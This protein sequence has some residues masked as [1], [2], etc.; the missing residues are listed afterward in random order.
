MV[1]VRSLST[2][3]SSAGGM[4]AFTCGRSLFT[5]FATWITLAPG[6]R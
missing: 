2:V 6:W 3:M 5:A 4:S 1:S